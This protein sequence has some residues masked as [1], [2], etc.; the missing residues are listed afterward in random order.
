MLVISG[1][2]ITAYFYLHQPPSAT[3]TAT[4][5]THTATPTGAIVTATMISSGLNLVL[6]LN[7]THFMAGQAV[8]ATADVRNPSPNVS[9]VSQAWVWPIPSLEDWMSNLGGCPSFLSTQFYSGHYTIS[10]ISVA[11][12]LQISNPGR[13][14]PCG[15]PRD[16]GF[17]R[18]QPL[19]DKVAFSP[20]SSYTGPGQPVTMSVEANGYYPSNQSSNFALFSPGSYT[21]AAGDEWGNVTIAYFSVTAN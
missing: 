16:G 5:G 21:V 18:F 9:D 3:L 19:S 15:P 17:F 12:P 7:A 8:N 11:T 10:N 1:T 13:V 20:P 6:M 2:I 4:S 14:V